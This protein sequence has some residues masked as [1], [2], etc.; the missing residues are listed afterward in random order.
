MERSDRSKRPVRPVAG[1]NRRRP[2]NASPG[3][4]PSGQAHVGPPRTP[5]NVAKTKEEQQMEVG[6]VRVWRKGKE[7]KK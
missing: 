1:V 4:T 2:K 3:G 5:S 7:D 6:K